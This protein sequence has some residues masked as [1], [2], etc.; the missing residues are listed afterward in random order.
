MQS[1]A[2]NFKKRADVALH[3]MELQKALG[4]LK[5]GCSAPP[6]E[7]LQGAGV[8]LT[9]PTAIEAALQRFDRTITELAEILE[10]EV[11]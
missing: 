3:D 8:D 6:I 5:G 1:Q 9:Q 2:H 4:M 10:V 7:L 11:P